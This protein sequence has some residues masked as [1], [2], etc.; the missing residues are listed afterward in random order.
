VI[1]QPQNPTKVDPAAADK[2]DEEEEGDDSDDSEE[3]AD[4]GPDP[5]EAK[6]RF[7]IGRAH[8]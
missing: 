4:T 7:E 2:P 6:R 1:A 8:V 5:E 3:A